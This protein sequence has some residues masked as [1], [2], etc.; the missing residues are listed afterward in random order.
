MCSQ[1]HPATHKNYCHREHTEPKP[2]THTHHSTPA[3]G[4]ECLGREWDTDLCF[5]FLFKSSETWANIL[6]FRLQYMSIFFA[7][8]RIGYK[9]CESIKNSIIWF[10]TNSN[11]I[12]KW[13]P[14]IGVSHECPNRLGFGEICQ[15]STQ[16]SFCGLAADSSLL[17]DQSIPGVGN[18]FPRGHM[19]NLNCLGGPNQP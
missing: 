11:N 16:K 5:I 4:C 14:G 15:L 6:L 8:F 3:M 19:R 7:L 12:P 13:H 9:P 1:L 10:E 18:K 2:P 17:R